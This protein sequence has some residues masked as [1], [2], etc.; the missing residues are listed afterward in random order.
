MKGKDQQIISKRENNISK[1]IDK[2]GNGNR[3][4]LTFMSNFSA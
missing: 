1:K 4:C 3:Q 2:F